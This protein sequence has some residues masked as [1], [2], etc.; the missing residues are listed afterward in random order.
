MD[1]DDNTGPTAVTLG[2]G[3]FVGILI[4]Y[5]IEKIIKIVDVIVGLYL[6]ELAYLQYQSSDSQ[7]K[8]E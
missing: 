4:W 1:E 5:A 3:F 7:H 2:G 6:A 8:L